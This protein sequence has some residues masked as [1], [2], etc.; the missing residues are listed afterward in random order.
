MG[1]DSAHG[2][3]RRDAGGFVLAVSLEDYHEE[4]QV[5]PETLCILKCLFGHRSF[6]VWSV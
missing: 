3:E 2:T 5:L 6:S 1:V 4:L